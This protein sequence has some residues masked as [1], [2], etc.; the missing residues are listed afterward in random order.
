MSRTES[1]EERKE[2]GERRGRKWPGW[3]TK[4]A[5]RAEQAV[6]ATSEMVRRKSSQLGRRQLLLLVP[7]G[8]VTTSQQ[9]LCSLGK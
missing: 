3:P 8:E 2:L 6:A 9:I 5:K 7:R 1:T 4:A